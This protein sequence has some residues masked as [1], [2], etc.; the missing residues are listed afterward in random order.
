MVILLKSKSSYKR[1]ERLLLVE[2]AKAP[3]ETSTRSKQKISRNISLFAITHAL[4]FLWVA[5][6]VREVGLCGSI[7]AVWLMMCHSVLWVFKRYENLT[8]CWI[9]LPPGSLLFPTIYY[10]YHFINYY[11]CWYF[12]LCVLILIKIAAAEWKY[13]SWW[14]R[15]EIYWGLDDEWMDPRSKSSRVHRGPAEVDLKVHF[16]RTQQE[17]G[18]GERRGVMLA[19]SFCEW[20]NC[21]CWRLVAPTLLWLSTLGMASIRSWPRQF[22]AL[23]SQ[24]PVLLRSYM[25]AWVR[26]R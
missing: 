14:I 18:R 2:G 1:T 4:I 24:W 9:S 12:L 23:L 10:L 17:K 19:Q 20:R 26:H 25:G 6:Y 22:W 15:N 5:G 8:S 11:W 3:A 16:W 7:S 21:A 13:S